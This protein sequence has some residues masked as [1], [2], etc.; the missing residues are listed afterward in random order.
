MNS[1]KIICLEYRA[2]KFIRF[3]KQENTVLLYLMDNNTLDQL[4]NLDDM[5]IKELENDEV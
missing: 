3:Q 1:F 5:V 4:H 2:Y